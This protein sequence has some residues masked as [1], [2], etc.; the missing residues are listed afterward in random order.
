MPNLAWLL[1]QK[2]QVVQKDYL[3]MEPQLP[4]PQQRSAKTI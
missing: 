2:M 3:K 1:H 4:K